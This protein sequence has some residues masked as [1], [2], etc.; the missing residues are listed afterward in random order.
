M[1]IVRVL[2]PYAVRRS[3]SMT[4]RI[5]LLLAA[6]HLASCSPADEDHPVVTRSTAG[7]GFTAVILTELDSRKKISAIKEV[8]AITKLGLADAKEMGKW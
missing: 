3:T 8:R 7:T 4:T 1:N 6:I 5:A 2:G